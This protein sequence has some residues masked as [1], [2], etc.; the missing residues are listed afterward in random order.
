VAVDLGQDRG[1]GA[2][3]RVRGAG[4]DLALTT[5]GE[6][7]VGAHDGGLHDGAPHVV[8]GVAAPVRVANTAWCG[9]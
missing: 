5:G 6:Q 7:L 8:D 4:R 9:P 2:P 1:E 3:Q